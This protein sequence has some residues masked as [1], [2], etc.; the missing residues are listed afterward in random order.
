[1]R[2]IIPDPWNRKPFPGMKNLQFRYNVLAAHAAILSPRDNMNET[3]QVILRRR[4]LRAYADQ[5]LQLLHR[6]AILQ[7]ALRAPTAG[8]MMLY[9]ILEVT[10]QALKDQLAVTCDNQPFLAKAPLVLLF[11][12]DYQRWMDY[13]E[14]TG[15]P[16]CAAGLGREPRTP[17]AG[18]LVLA[19]C[20]ALIAAQTAVIAAESLGVGS[21]Y[22][23]D[24]LE[25]AE[26]V[27]QMFHLP[28]CTFP[29]T[30]LCFGYPRSAPGAPVSRF[31]QRFIVHENT[32]HRLEP[33]ELAEM[34][35]PLEERFAANPPQSGAQNAGQANYLR[36]F[37]ADFSVEMSRSVRAW[38][39]Y[40]E[41][42]A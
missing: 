20:D 14:Q 2:I 5:P 24:I 3:L 7:A 42:G 6:N 23:G 25:N 32:Y 29:V 27:R 37:T 17:Q 26:T 34:M 31:D 19:C 9:S 1:M 21:C 36:K 33:A 11:L 28:R 30:L 40:W 41:E 16:Q 18:D 12:A 22:I 4:S 13:Y 38:I 15:A 35:Q 8:N 10:D 39:R